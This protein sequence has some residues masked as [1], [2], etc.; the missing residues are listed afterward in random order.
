LEKYKKN[1]GFMFVLLF[2]IKIIVWV[3]L[4]WDF[5]H[6][7]G[8]NKFDRFFFEEFHDEKDEIIKMNDE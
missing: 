4:I 1:H 3:Y 8:I 5:F 7:K 6:T 2:L